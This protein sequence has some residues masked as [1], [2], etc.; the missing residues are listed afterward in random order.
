MTLKEL[1]EREWKTGPCRNPLKKCC[2]CWLPVSN[3][4]SCWLGYP[5]TRRK[6]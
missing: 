5:S 4:I 1:M 3:L 6:K 2:W